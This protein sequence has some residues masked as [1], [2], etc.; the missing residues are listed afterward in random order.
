MTK[1]LNQVLAIEKSIKTRVYNQITEYHKATQKSDLLEGF[2]KTYQPLRE[3]AVG[4]PPQSK[5]VQFNATEVFK[6]VQK[7]L[8]ELFNVTASKDWSNCSA[9]ADIAVDGKTL[10]TG[11][12]AT[13]LLFLDKQLTDLNTFVSKFSE[14][15]PSVDWQVDSAHGLWKSGVIE[16]QRTEKVQEGITLAPPTK[17][18]PA[19]TQLITKDVVVGKWVSTRFSG[20]MPKTRKVQLVERIQKLHSAVKEALEEANTATAVEQNTADSIFGYLFA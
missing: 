15:D 11:A 18:H 20:A 16:T 14:L 17:E 4:Q 19:Q 5:N 13:Y 6:D 1:K 7:S 2:Q 9:K 10:V 8:S 3:D 12:P